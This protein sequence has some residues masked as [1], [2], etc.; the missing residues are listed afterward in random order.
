MDAQEQYVIVGMPDGARMAYMML[1]G[2]DVL[3]MANAVAVGMFDGDEDMARAFGDELDETALG[4]LDA[5]EAAWRLA[6]ADSLDDL[7]GDAD[8]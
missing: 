2:A 8:D 6:H 4:Q 7:M 3:G 5:D 1:R